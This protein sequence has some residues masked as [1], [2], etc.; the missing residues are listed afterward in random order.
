MLHSSS[1]VVRISTRMNKS[2]MRSDNGGI[3]YTKPRGIQEPGKGFVAD[4]GS[5]TVD[6]QGQGSIVR[7][8]PLASRLDE[9]PY[10]LPAALIAAST[11]S[12]LGRKIGITVL[13]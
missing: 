2:W 6:L 12:S 3:I 4:G 11:R 10:A 7:S 5:S 8:T 13:R 1:L 9:S